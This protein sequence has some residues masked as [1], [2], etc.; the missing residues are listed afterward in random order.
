MLPPA[1]KDVG[2]LS[3]VFESARA[4]VT[5]SG[6]NQLRL[7]R[8]KHSI[9][10]LVDGLG[11]E[12]LANAGASARFLNG[13]EKSV[14]RCEFPSTTATSIGGF[15]TGLRSNGHGL[16]GYSVFD[17]DL[18]EPVNLLTGWLNAAQAVEA[19]LVPSISETSGELLV[20]AVGPSA[21]RESGFT[22]LTMAGAQYLIAEEIAERFAVAFSSL[23]S[24]SSLTYLYIP[25]L[26]QT[27]HKFGVDS[28]QWLN[29][30]E[31]LDSALRLSIGTL[32]DSVGVLLTADHGVLDVPATGQVLL[33]EFD[34][35]RD[36]VMHTAGDPR[37]N[38]VYVT[39]EDSIERILLE[40]KTAFG[41]RAYVVTPN[42]LLEAN[43]CNWSNEELSSIVP[44]LIIIWSGKEV[45]YDRRFAKPHHLK[46][47]GQHGGISD[48]ETRVPLMK[49]GGY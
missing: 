13:S 30:L 37:C 32:P 43:W 25:E 11:A 45:G 21:Y 28:I 4:S 46:M 33:D 35:Y 17:R 24:E 12:N 14:I 15:A 16:I 36:L 42:E 2:R 49:F 26:D 29:A 10:I 3:T 6:D 39:N 1:P 9:V 20:R 23:P 47:I 31:D 48:V 44:D 22:Q 34:W 40:L 27:A 18:N 7:K 41:S 5:G 19:K 8:V 38:F